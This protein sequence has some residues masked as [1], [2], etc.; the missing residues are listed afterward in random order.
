M[1][2]V[3]G[4]ALGAQ[5]RLTGDQRTTGAQ[6]TPRAAAVSSGQQCAVL[7]RLRLRET[8]ARA[9]KASW[10][11]HT[12]VCTPNNNW[13]PIE[14]TNA[15]C[16]DLLQ[17]C[18]L[19]FASCSLNTAAALLPREAPPTLVLS[20]CASSQASWRLW[21]SKATLAVSGFRL[22]QPRRLE[23]V[24]GPVVQNIAAE[25]SARLWDCFYSKTDAQVKEA[26]RR[27][28]KTQMRNAKR[29]SFICSFALFGSCRSAER[30]CPGRW[31]TVV[32]RTRNTSAP[33]SQ[34]GHHRKHVSV[35]R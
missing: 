11:G 5:R 28:C 8:T 2:N 7:L 34:T 10:P 25:S 29:S 17:P 27:E 33:H 13:V 21:R 14:S 30:V 23:S 9:E 31:P 12:R 32:L 22:S 24:H 3:Y 15:I 1:C 6:Q 16:D 35:S 19:S 26:S 18:P 20:H 4:N